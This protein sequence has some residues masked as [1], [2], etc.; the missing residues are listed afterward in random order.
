MADD[1]VSDN[2]HLN[3]SIK[4]NQMPDGGQNVS[5]SISNGE[6]ISKNVPNIL[7]FSDLPITN[8]PKIDNLLKLSKIL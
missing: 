5:I 8:D 7:D 2:F 6:E 4:V 1:S 3:P